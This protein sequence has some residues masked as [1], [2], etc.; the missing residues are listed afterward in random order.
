M[1]DKPRTD[2]SSPTCRILQVYL[3]K[4]AAEPIDF[5]ALQAFIEGKQRKQTPQ[6]LMAINVL[7]LIIHQ[8]PNLCVAPLFTAIGHE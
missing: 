8:A 7:Q 1:S 4:V 5:S 2:G 6:V 3:K